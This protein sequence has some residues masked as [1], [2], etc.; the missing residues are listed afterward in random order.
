M[1]VAPSHITHINRRYVGAR[2]PTFTVLTVLRDGNSAM[3]TRY[4]PD[5]RPDGYGHEVNFLPVGDTRTRPEPRWVRDGY[6]F[7]PDGYPILYYRYNSS[8]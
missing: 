1:V 3:G 5:T 4:P 2:E 7:L 8:L 6:F